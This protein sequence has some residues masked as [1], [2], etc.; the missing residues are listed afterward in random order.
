MYI[1]HTLYDYYFFLIFKKF[2]YSIFYSIVF[3][4][5]YKKNFSFFFLLPNMILGTGSVCV[6]FIC[7]NVR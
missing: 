6:L 7:Y 5:V 3:F 2:L 4:I 1:L